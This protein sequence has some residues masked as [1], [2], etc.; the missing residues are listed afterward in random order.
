[1]KILQTTIRTLLVAPLALGLPFGVIH[2]APKYIISDLGTLGGIYSS[3]AALNES[4]QV[5][6]YSHLLANSALHPFLWKDG[7]PRL[8]LNTL[9]GT[10]AMAL[11]I[12]SS[13]QVV[14][15][16]QITGDTAVRGFVWNVNAMSPLANLGGTRS[17]ATA[18]NDNG[19][20]T[21]AASLSGDIAEHG[22]V[23]PNALAAS[24]TDLGTL[25]G[26]NSQGN[27]INI[28]GQ[29]VGYA[30]NATGV[31]HA[32]RWIPPYNAASRLDLGTLGGTYSEAYAINTA[33]QVTGVSTNTGDARFRGFVWQSGQGMVDIGSLTATSTHTA[34]MDINA[35]GDVVG[36]S[37]TAGGAAKRAIVRKTGV[38]LEDL[39]GLVLPNT[40]WVL[41]EA[42][43]INDAG[44]IV[45]VGILTKVDTVNNLNRV[46]PHAF[47][48][49]PDTVKPTIT[50][51]STVT[52]NGIQPASIG[53]AVAQ[54]NLD[55]APVI[56]SNRPT[57]FPNGSTTVVWTATD[58]NGNAATCSQIVKIEVQDTTA[59]LVSVT[60]NPAVPA[61]SGWY[62]TAPSV[63]WTVTDAESAVASKNG[64]VDNAAVGNTAPAGTSFSCAATSA[65][66]T[67]IPVVTP[68][69]K[70][71]AV[72][73][74]LANIPV[75]FTQQATS[76]SGSAVSYTN[77]TAI[78]TFS[79][80]SVT[81]VSCLPASGTAFPMGATTVNCTV[82]D[83]AGNSSSASFVVTVADQTPPEVVFESVPAAPSASGWYLTR[84]S[85]SWTSTDQESAVSATTAG[86]APVALQANTAATGRNIT[87][88]ATSIG[89]TTTKTV[90][91]KVDNTLPTLTGVP[92]N[93][94]QAA[95]SEAG[96]AVSYALPTA[97]DTFSLVK[98][99]SLSCLPASG[100]VFPVGVTT[101]NCSVDDNA[102]NTRNASFSVTV[103]LADNTPPIVS[104]Q[105]A[106][107][108]AN[109]LSGWYTTSPSVTWSVTDPESAITSPACADVGSVG[110]TAGQTF[111]CS[112]TSTGGTTGPVVTPTIRVDAVAPTFSGVPAAFTR[113]A[114]SA[115]GAAVTYIAPSALDAFS[116]VNAAGV[117]CLPA[118][119]AT[120]PIGVNT[121]TCS[122][123]DVA[124]NTGSASFNVTVADQTAPVFS[125][126]PTTVTL[127]QGQALPQLVA[128]DNVSTPVVTRTPIGT[129]PLGLTT[130]I[131]TATDQAGLSANCVQ[132]VTVN[133]AVTETITVSG[134]QCKVRSST[135]GEWT[136]RGTSSIGANNNIQ[137]YRTAT[138]PSDLTSNRLGTALTISAGSWQY[139]NKNGPAC[140]ATISLRSALGTVRQNIS[141]SVR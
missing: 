77:P 55:T 6:G 57:T 10:H 90:N 112:A 7:V 46:E 8:D 32:M 68:N 35:S 48:L 86:C 122:A 11:G 64:C 63:T 74:V 50:C 132:Q 70:V 52:T 72:A 60:V 51:P 22:V 81:G 62:L 33:G 131:W 102:G 138:V 87:C 123:T 95:T 100:T 36:Y 53:A 101:V 47:L 133:A 94:V 66:G 25:G 2:A 54:D 116:G 137:L 135:S 117:S 92:A 28:N 21:G 38:A 3:A 27:D 58:A 83:V 71:D 42:H 41:S 75:A 26:A 49:T 13:G 115:A 40:G 31:T 85:T 130:V 106:P 113:A 16:S 44:Q 39:N 141:V 19:V 114:T 96:I 24:P 98:A 69:I 129:L 29:V 79:G 34:G 76:P 124:G 111:S 80:V 59:P 17:R 56:T 23:W 108:V 93:I 118:S 119:G 1:M 78:D 120:L 109:G 126:C 128:T 5:V 45:G 91:I 9:G 88:E 4:G 99:G 136:V 110:N 18:I 134:P 139:T 14:G 37:S 43:A 30:E 89:G 103:N 67:S 12:N 97:T 82:S 105:V 65:G 84:P 125:N 61:A 107:S 20:M 121:I 140:S 104:F 15:N 73:P 127:T